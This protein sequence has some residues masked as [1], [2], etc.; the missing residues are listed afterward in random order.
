MLLLVGGQTAARTSTKFGQSSIVT[1]ISGELYSDERIVT[2]TLLPAQIRT[3][4]A[5][6]VELVASPG[7]GNA[8]WVSSAQYMLDYG[9]FAYNDV[10][11]GEDLVLRTGTTNVQVTCDE[12]LCLNA[13]A[14]SDQYAR[15]QTSQLASLGQPLNDN[16]ALSIT[17]TAGEWATSNSDLNGNSPIHYVIRY[18]V[19]PVDISP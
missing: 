16:T 3:L 1:T 5:T 2:G 4:N 6:P 10:G 11:S 7:S 17:I 9:S 8:I 15:S 12:T 19:V 14:T 13:D 18:K